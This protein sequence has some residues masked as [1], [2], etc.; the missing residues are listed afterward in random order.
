L[1]EEFERNSPTRDVLIAV[2]WR[3]VVNAQQ[4]IREP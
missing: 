4:S 1:F 2:N 3:E